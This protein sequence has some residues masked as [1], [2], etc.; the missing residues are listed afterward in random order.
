MMQNE[1]HPAVNAL[2]NVSFVTVTGWNVSRSEVS[3]LPS[4]QD[5]E[6]MTFKYELGCKS[7]IVES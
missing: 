3:L 5:Y 4:S 7:A 6:N 1:I 2:N